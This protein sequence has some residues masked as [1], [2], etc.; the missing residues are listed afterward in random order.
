M[1][2]VFPDANKVTMVS[3]IDKETDDKNKIS[4]YR[5]VSM[6]NIFSV[7]YKIVLENN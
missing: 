5:P 2:R 3:T 6:L 1:N 4:N 7:V